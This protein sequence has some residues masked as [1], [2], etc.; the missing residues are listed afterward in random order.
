VEVQNGAETVKMIC[1]VFYDA[2]GKPWGRNDGAVVFW[3]EG[4]DPLGYIE[5]MKT[6]LDKP[7]LTD[8]DFRK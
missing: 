5:M 8:K 4:Q 6:A 7:V 2:Y 1:E 3:G